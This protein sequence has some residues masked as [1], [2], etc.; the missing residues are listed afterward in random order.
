MLGLAMDSAT[1]LLLLVALL[2]RQ[3]AASS[4]LRL[5]VSSAGSAGLDLA[6]TRAR[7]LHCNTSL[8]KIARV[9]T[10]VPEMTV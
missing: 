2:V 3:G 4:R 5:M 6:S 1:A 7:I 9:K 8:S 10:S